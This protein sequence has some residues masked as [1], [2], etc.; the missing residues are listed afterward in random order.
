MFRIDEIQK[1]IYRISTYNPQFGISINQF[2]IADEAPALIHTGIYS[3]F[4]GIREQIRQVLDPA[5][6]RYVVIPHFESDECGGID[7]F[8]AEARGAQLVCSQVGAAI[9]LMPGLWNTGGFGERAPLT[10]WQDDTL[11]LGRHRLRFLMTPHVHHWD[12]MMIFEESEGV[13]FP[14]DLFIQPGEQPPV[15]RED[16]AAPMI[17]LYQAVGIMPSEDAVH[18]VLDRMKKLP[19]R[20]VDPMHGASIPADA[21]A[22][23]VRALREEPFTYAGRLFDREVF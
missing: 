20:H 5:T 11:E 3:D 17:A 2:L 15:S 21:L 10:V 18:R 19:L 1:D 7:R 23:Y 4:D 22:P 16:L 13:L 6:L 14:A 8:L 9:N 12:S